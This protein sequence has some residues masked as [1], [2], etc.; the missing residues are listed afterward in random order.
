MVYHVSYADC[1]LSLSQKGPTVNIDGEEGKTGVGV[2][3]GER[4]E[5]GWGREGGA[6]WGRA[7]G[8]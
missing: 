3:E 5:G 2:E 1:S 4:A 8:G 7:E 6:W